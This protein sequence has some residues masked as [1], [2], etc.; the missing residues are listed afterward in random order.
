[1]QETAKKKKKQK[2]EYCY[3][4]TGRYRCCYI[5]NTKI[6]AKTICGQ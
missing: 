1:M 3:Y 2:K 6:N 5:C 4:C